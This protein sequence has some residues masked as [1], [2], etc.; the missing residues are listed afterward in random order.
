VQLSGVGRRSA[1]A[2]PQQVGRTPFQVLLEHREL[3]EAAT[4]LRARATTT[5]A[6]RLA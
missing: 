4:A 5:V 3:L 6:N 2:Q 1:D